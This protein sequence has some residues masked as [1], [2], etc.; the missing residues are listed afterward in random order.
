MHKNTLNEYKVEIHNVPTFYGVLDEYY[1]DVFRNCSITTRRAYD[2]D[3]NRYILEDLG[4]RPLDT[5][6]IEDCDAV[7]EKIRRKGLSPST[8]QHYC[9]LI[10][11]VIRCA[12]EHGICQDI[13]FGS[14]YSLPHVEEKSKAHE[15]EFVRTQKSLRAE[16]EKALFEKVMVDPEQE[17]PLMGLAL[18]FGLGVRNNE[19]CGLKFNGIQEMPYHPGNYCAWIYETTKGATNQLKAGGKTRNAPRILP[20]PPVLADFLM[21]RKAFLTSEIEKGNI[22]LDPERGIRDVNDLPVACQKNDYTEHCAS[23]HLTACGRVIL[24]EIK[25]REDE[26]AFID[27]SLRDQAMREKMGVI[28]KDP[29][30]YL[31]RR[32]LAGHLNIL[33]LS[34]EEIYYYM[35]HDMGGDRTLRNE[36]NNEAFLYEIL[37]KLRNRPLFNREYPHEVVYDLPDD[38][39]VLQFQNTHEIT[40][41]I[42][43]L[44]PGTQIL[45]HLDLPEP[46]DPAEITL[47]K[48]NGLRK[49][50]LTVTRILRGKASEEA[51]ITEY[52]HSLYEASR[53]RKK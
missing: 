8:V 16:E 12:A 53:K 52:Y 33:G 29:T 6:E 39:R 22:R 48:G 38:G 50:Y 2:R 31:L 45:L 17:G 28:E 26:I 13:L 20:I 34:E 15:K 36:Y 3:Y 44:N 35:G 9:Y 25:V 49:A 41:R 42:P 43:K 21:Q 27:Q 46:D 18:M 7:I 5:L 14:V 1:D 32:N 24:R 4:E 37:E 47:E 10:R 51:N 19:A 23:R 40:I 30:A 11:V